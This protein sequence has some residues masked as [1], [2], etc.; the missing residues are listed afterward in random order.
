[1]SG[2]YRFLLIVLVS[3]ALASGCSREEFKRIGYMLGSQYSCRQSNNYRPN[4][5]VK[6]L[7]CSNPV[8]AK[9]MSYEDYQKQR[10]EL[11]KHQD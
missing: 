11:L 10:A 2:K 7:E 8:T 6:D 1:M 3:T 4:E 9:T 5:G